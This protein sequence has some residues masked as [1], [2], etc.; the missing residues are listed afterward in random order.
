MIEWITFGSEDVSL[1]L[2]F[3]LASHQ[4]T[5][6]GK[7][8]KMFAQGESKLSHS[9]KTIKPNNIYFQYSVQPLWACD[10]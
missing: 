8:Q 9:I 6:L 5:D 1:L 7:N 10:M 3:N 2:G 4:K